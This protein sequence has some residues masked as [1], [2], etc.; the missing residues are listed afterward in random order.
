MCV[1]Y[2]TTCPGANLTLPRDNCTQA[3]ESRCVTYLLGGNDLELN[4][5]KSHDYLGKGRTEDMQAGNSK[6]ETRV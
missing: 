1:N 4:F 5:L 2:I 6:R 3:S